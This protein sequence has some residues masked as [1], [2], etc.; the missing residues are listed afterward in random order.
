MQQ[1]LKTMVLLT[2]DG[3]INKKPVVK[4]IHDDV[5]EWIQEYFQ[6]QGYAMTLDCFQAEFLSK[7]YSKM[8]TVTALILLV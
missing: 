8:C 5:V 1:D 7:K 2:D 3:D 6:F 4:N